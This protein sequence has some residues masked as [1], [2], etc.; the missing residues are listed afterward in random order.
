[1]QLSPQK[2]ELIKEYLL[3]KI[4]PY[5]IIGFGSAFGGNMLSES[6]IDL[7]F[8]SDQK[9]SLYE[10]FMTGQGLADMLGRDVDLVD[11][12]RASTVF[13]AR[14]ITTGKVL[15]SNDE[16]RRMYFYMLV[17]KKY[18]RLNEERRC[19]LQAISRRRLPGKAWPP[20]GTRS[21]K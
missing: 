14:V 5:L 7:A 21:H 15:Y 18:A 9:H 11:L 6:D 2:I 13:Q 12:D 17:L 16:T 20:T 19:I 3:E 1:M 8:L 4:S 10:I